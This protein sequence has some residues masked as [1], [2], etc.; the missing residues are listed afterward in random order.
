MIY[1]GFLVAKD[2]DYLVSILSMMAT[3]AIASAGPSLGGFQLE[4]VRNP[5]SMLI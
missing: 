3:S 4:I 1:K 5:S 2:L